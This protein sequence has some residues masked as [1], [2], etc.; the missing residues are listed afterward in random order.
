MNERVWGLNFF[1]GG[2][3][4][5]IRNGRGEVW[6]GV[7]TEEILRVKRETHYMDFDWFRLTN[8]SVLTEIF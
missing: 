4:L 7:H 6:C 5:H 3:A 8:E 1:F 2:V